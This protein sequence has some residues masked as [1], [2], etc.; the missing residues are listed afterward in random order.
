MKNKVVINQIIDHLKDP[1]NKE[2]YQRMTGVLQLL[3]YYI[4]HKKVYRL[5]KANQLLCAAKPKESKRYVKYRILCPEGP[6]RLLEID[7]KYVWID[8]E[9]RHGYILT[10]IDVFTRVVL[11][12]KVDRQETKGSGTSMGKCYRESFRAT[13]NVWMGI[14]H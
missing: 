6:L 14:R 1:L 3:G 2:G 4:N 13:S 12:W 10:I 5:M 8:G 9:D 7:I 11:Y